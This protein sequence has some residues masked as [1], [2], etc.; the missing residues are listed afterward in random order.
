MS[1]IS[2][3]SLLATISTAFILLAMA[4]ERSEFRHK[5]AAK[6]DALTGLAN[7]RS[8]FQEAAR[9]TQGGTRPIA[10]LM[11]DLDHFKSV[12]DRF[13][14]AM[15]DK[16]LKIFAETMV[17]HLRPTDIVGRLGGEEFAVLL[18]G[19]SEVGAQTVAERLRS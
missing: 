7:R 15:G 4:K 2:T 9:L 12:N 19:A 3:G 1:V 10:L 17:G 8:F 5:T 13:G 16:V 6:T 18:P 14:H 11:I